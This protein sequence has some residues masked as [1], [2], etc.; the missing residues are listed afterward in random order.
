MLQIKIEAI[1]R[2]QELKSTL[3]RR[4]V[5][6]TGLSTMGVMLLPKC[7]SA[8]EVNDKDFKEKLLEG[9]ENLQQ[10]VSK[11]LGDAK[12]AVTTKAEEAISSLKF[13]DDKAAETLTEV[14]SSIDETIQQDKLA[15][16]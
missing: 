16:N 14:K 5:M 11:S 12:E 3:S 1:P 10:L 9:I 7:S 4:R 8:K 6:F 13:G 15:Q 2:D